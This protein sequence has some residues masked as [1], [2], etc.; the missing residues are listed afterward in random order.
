MYEPEINFDGRALSCMRVCHRRMN[1][2]L[3]LMK[4][5][6]LR[7]EVDHSTNSDFSS[8][9]VILDKVQQISLKCEGVSLDAIVDSGCEITCIN[10]TKSL[11][12]PIHSA[13][14]IILRPAFWKLYDR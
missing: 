5:N 10:S 11:H 14:E 9:N 6:A 4:P 8:C 13:N 3:E 12:S 2:R 1:A 7:V